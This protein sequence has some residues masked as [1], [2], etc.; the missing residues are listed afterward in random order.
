MSVYT[1]SQ[2]KT[3]ADDTAQ[4]ANVIFEAHMPVLHELALAGQYNGPFPTT[5]ND[6]VAEAVKLLFDAQGYTV[7]APTE[8]SA[9]YNLIS[10]EEPT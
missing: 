8:E 2:L 10:W 7:T 5:P 6:V 4:N 9:D 3:L 1:A